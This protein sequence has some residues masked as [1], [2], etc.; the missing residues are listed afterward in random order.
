MGCSLLFPQKHGFRRGIQA[1]PF[2]DRCYLEFFFRTLISQESGCYV[3]FGDKPAAM[4]VY[5]DRQDFKLLT[6]SRRPISG[7]SKEKLGLKVWQKYRHLFPLKDYAIVNTRAFTPSSSGAVFLIN[8]KRLLTT[9][10]Q[11]FIEFQKS[12]PEFRT[13]KHLLDGMLDDATILHRVCFQH[14]VL[15]GIILGFGKDNAVLFAREMQLESFLFPQSFICGRYRENPLAR[16]TPQ[17]GFSSLEEEL[18]AIQVKGGGIFDPHDETLVNWTLHFPLGFLVD[19]TKT[20][21]KKLYVKYKQQRIRA[22]RAYDK[23]NFLEITLRELTSGT[24]TFR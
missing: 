24:G 9:L 16:P 8:K 7:F 18:T 23:G 2:E 1:I 6:L 12:F 10:S 22:T 4:M 20:D 15:L 3:L 19:T 13:P 11:N 5:E 21:P 17:P 14:D